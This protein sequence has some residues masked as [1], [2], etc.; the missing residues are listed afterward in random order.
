MKERAEK[1][2]RFAEEARKYLERSVNE[3]EKERWLKIAEG[4]EQLARDAETRPAN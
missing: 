1:F 3:A 2:R 4:W